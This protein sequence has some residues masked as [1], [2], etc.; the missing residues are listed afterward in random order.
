MKTVNLLVGL[1]FLVLGA[2][3]LIAAAAVLGEFNAHAYICMSALKVEGVGL[4]ISAQAS[5]SALIPHATLPL[6]LPTCSAL[7]D[8]SRGYNLLG[9]IFLIVGGVVMYV[10]IQQAAPVP[11]PVQAN[12]FP[13]PQSI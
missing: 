2:T 10:G 4:A 9:I 7:N 12:P 13:L 5:A 3:F 8:L 6:D 11:Q 1:I